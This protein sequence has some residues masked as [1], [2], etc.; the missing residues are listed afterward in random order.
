MEKFELVGR[1]KHS[2]TDIVSLVVE[3]ENEGEAFEKAR[4]VLKTFPQENNVPDVPYCYIE[5]RIFND[6]T[7]EDVQRLDEMEDSA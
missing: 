7:V 1:V 5:H 2:I 3:A 4:D 6:T